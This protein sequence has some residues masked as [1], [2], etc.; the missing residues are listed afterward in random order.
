MPKKLTLEDFIKR[1]TVVHNA[2][3]SYENVV[4]INSKTKVQITCPTHGTFT[5]IP[6]THLAGVRCPGCA[7]NMK[8]TK[9][10]FI[11][12]SI[13]VHKDKY[14]YSLVP[15]DTHSSKLPIICKTHGVFYQSYKRHIAGD[16]CPEC[17]IINTAA[18]NKL[19]Q[20][21]AIDKIKRNSTVSWGFSKFKYVS[22][23]KKVTVTCPV[24]GDKSIIANSL[25]NGGG[26]S[27]CSISG[28]NYNKPAILYYLS[29]NNGAAYKLG[30]TNLNISKRYSVLERNS[31]EVLWELPFNTG[32]ACKDTEQALLKMFKEYR[33]NGVPLLKKGNTE[34][35]YKNILPNLSYSNKEN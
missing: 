7:G 33:Y 30:I 13:E 32:K 12:K 10:S 16:N 20:E 11:E 17:G 9:E 1:S 28:F 19:S 25:F 4:Y 26:C 27:D 14:D 23:H 34:L 24:H 35:F 21:E 22:A 5:Q 15:T 31:F 29:I 2:F 8:Y 18:A 3:Y 6:N